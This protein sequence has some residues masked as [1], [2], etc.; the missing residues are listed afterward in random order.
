METKICSKCKCEKGVEDFPFKNKTKNVRHYT[1]SVC[2][3][4][5]RKI[6]YDKNKKTTLDRIQKMLTVIE[7]GMKI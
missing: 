7:N 6:S 2:W 4:E 5:I 3:K 1:C